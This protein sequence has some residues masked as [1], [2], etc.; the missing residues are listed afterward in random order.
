[1][2]C[3]WSAVV[4]TCADQD[5]AE[6]FEKG[7]RSHISGIFIQ[8]VLLMSVF[9]QRLSFQMFYFMISNPE[10]IVKCRWGSGSSV[11]ST[12]GSWWSLGGG[13]GSK[14]PDFFYIWRANK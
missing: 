13:S 9:E 7:N 12:V 6:A 11:S 10:I 14:G 5:S 3:L 1:M 4:I 8:A 2:E